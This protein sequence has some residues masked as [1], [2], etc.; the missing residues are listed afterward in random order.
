MIT[1]RPPIGPP[2]PLTR[3]TFLTKW[4]FSHFGQTN[5]R[6]LLWTSRIIVL[7]SYSTLVHSKLQSP[8]SWYR[9]LLFIIVHLFVNMQTY[10]KF[11]AFLLSLHYLYA[12]LLEM[13]DEPITINCPCLRHN[14]HFTAWIITLLI[15]LYLDGDAF[16]QFL[17]MADDTYMATCLW[18]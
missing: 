13:S 6:F 15:N 12:V 10:K 4:G 8:H 16:L 5:N 3:Y 1:F 9:K 17:N 2:H 14:F 7:P 18:M 11:S